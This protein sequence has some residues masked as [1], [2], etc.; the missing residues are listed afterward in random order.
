MMTTSKTKTI[1][2]I[3]SYSSHASPTTGSPT[4]IPQGS[5][6]VRSCLYTVYGIPQAIYHRGYVVVFP[7]RSP[8][9]HENL[10]RVENTPDQK[11]RYGCPEK[12]ASFICWVCGLQQRQEPIIYTF[13]TQ[14]PLVLRVR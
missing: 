11:V 2:E 6:H 12:L 14:P 4:G 13:W 1:Y 5:R 9:P 10:Q 3:I 8:R 7:M